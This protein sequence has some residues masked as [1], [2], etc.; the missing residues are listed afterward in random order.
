MWYQHSVD[1]STNN[2]DPRLSFIFH[3]TPNDVF[4]LT[5]GRSYSEPDPALLNTSTL[6]LSAPLSINQQFPLTPVASGGNPDL[7]PETAV[8]EEIAYGHRFNSRFTLQA[9]AYNTLENNAILSAT[10]P[11]TQFPQYVNAINQKIPGSNQTWLQAYLAHLGP[12]F[13]L[14]DLG[15]SLDANTAQA[16]YRGFDLNASVGL[17]RNLT[18]DAQYGVQSAQYKGIS[19]EILKNNIFLI[20]DA[21]IAKIPLQKA[22]SSLVYQNDAGSRIEFDETYIG[23]NNEY[24]RPAFWYTDASFAKETGPVTVT[25]GVNN[26]FNN[27]ATQYGYFGL[28]T[29]VPENQYGTDT[30]ALQQGSNAELYGLMP[31]QVWLTVQIKTGK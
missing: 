31:R 12:T 2:L 25:L 22:F 6:S 11:I 24:V 9:D 20:N 10:L 13:T 7:K 1:T 4:R 26:L 5:G 19:D 14:N 15:I 17:V 28:G 29:F 21:Q 30:S 16:L 23:N 27:A 18:F 8:D 3:P